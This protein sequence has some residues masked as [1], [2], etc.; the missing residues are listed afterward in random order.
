MQ[1]PEKGYDYSHWQYSAYGVHASPPSQESEALSS[2]HSGEETPVETRH[3]G[4]APPGRVVRRNKS[5]KRVRLT[6]GNLVIDL[7]VPPKL[8]LPRRGELETMKTRY[9]AVTCD[10]DE[11]EK[12]GFCLRQNLTGRRTELFIVI[13]MYN[14]DEILFCRTMHGVMKNISHL[15][16]RKNSQT[17]G[18]DAWKKVVVCIVADG[19]RK[20]HPRVLVADCLTLLGVFQPGGPM[21]NSIDKK[22]VTAHLFE[23]TTSFGIDSNLKFRYPDK[24]IV[25][26]QIIFCMKE[27]NQK[28]INSHRWFFNAFAPLLQASLRDPNVCV[29]LDVGT[30]PGPTAIY[31]L[32]KAFDVNSRVAGACGEISAYKGKNFSLLVNPL[33]SAQNLEYKISNILDKTTESMF[34][35][36]GVLPGAFSAYRYIALQNNKHG[37]GPLASY[38]KGEV[39]HGHDTD[40]FTSNMYLAED[41]ILCFELVAKA[42]SSWILKYVKGA[43]AETDVPDALP[44]FITQRRRWLN[45][46]LFAAIYAVAHAGQILRSGHSLTRKILLMIE[47]GYSVVN[48]LLSW[49]SIGN[50]YIFF[51]VLTSSLEDE[52]FRMPA[53]KYV[54]TVVQYLMASVVVACFLF[55]M[56]NKPHAS[57]WKYKITAI[58][59]AILM[60]YMLFASILC[61]LAAASQGGGAN[62]TMLFSVVITYGV[63]AISSI[64]AFDPWHMLTSFIPYLLLSPTYI[65][66][67]NIYA[68]SN[69]DDISWGTKQDSIVEVDLGAVVQDIHAQIDVEMATDKAD[70]NNIYEEALSNL[71][72]R[73]PPFSQNTPMSNTE[74]DQAAK[75]YYA[76]V[77]TN[78]SFHRL[79]VLLAWVLSN[80]LL[81]VGILG[82]GAAPSGTFSHSAAFSHTKAYLV[83]ILA[84]TA[85]QNLIRF[86]ASTCY[87][88]VRLFLGH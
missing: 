31:R 76:N 38:F 77:R 13:T 58:C 33:V 64:L 47:T 60:A 9:S 52:S 63:Y 87:L 19:R 69:L 5:K 46:S 65:N 35:Y 75:D 79:W 17:W 55:S 49:F 48:I 81:L 57:P 56:G 40:I 62:S 51:V 14:E 3:F 70:M 10:P 16:T 20:V 86:T 74:K 4:P 22:D 88:L 6:N 7:D 18:A 39:L 26:T 67:L 36:I 68:F 37:V 8:V 1:D 24:G 80:G 12:R 29:L 84:F 32:W 21:L 54:N 50:F 71:K 66:I 82:G 28:K 72:T 15:C 44:E 34:G 73:K 25:P 59:L 45:G 27:K 2:S 41:R 42:N 23:Y 61:A 11:F 30:R 83:F 53:I 43:I 85:I 78:A